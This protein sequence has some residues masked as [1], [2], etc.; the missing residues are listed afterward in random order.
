MPDADQ[1]TPVEDRD[2]PADTDTRAESDE[3]RSDDGTDGESTPAPVP[4]ETLIA[5]VELARE[6]LQ[7]ITPAS[8][9]G[10]PA[11]HVV[12]DDHVVSLLFANTMAGYPGW[13]WT[14][15]LSRTADDAAPNVLETELMPGDGAL[16]APQWVPWS[17]RLADYRAAQEAA[18]AAAADDALD[19]AD[20]TDEFDDDVAL[21]GDPRDRDRDGIEL[22]YD[23]DDVDAA[24]DDSDDD[25]SDEDEDDSDDDDSDEDDDRFEDE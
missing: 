7:E 16:L 18:A 22:E 24:S 12:V 20:D 15:T 19:D 3:H 1:E 9:V 4:D 14:V 6:A 2:I 8:T 21:S 23:E 25:D 5:A 11:G 13:F 17:E 10:E